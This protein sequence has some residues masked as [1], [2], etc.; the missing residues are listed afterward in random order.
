VSRNA[1]LHVV[2]LAAGSASRFGS[3]KQLARIDG[4]PMLLRVLSRA[5][6]VA[7]SSVSV[8]LGAHAAAIAPLVQR[9]SAAMIVNRA[10]SEGIGSSIRAA[11]E[12]L[13]SGCDGALLLLAD[14]INVSAIDMRHLADV[15][16]RQTNCIVAAQ[17]SG[18]IGV[19]AIFPRVDFRA[20][21]ELRGDRG[22]QSIIRR[23][24]ERLVTVPVPNAALDIDKPEDL[25][26]LQTVPAKS[27]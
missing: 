6:E 27:G 5:A 17:Y 21:G 12:R 8:V 9:S 11:A 24:P 18:I 20:L 26:L 25:L 10:W 22:A 1:A 2:V 14:Q 23:N 19:P 16:R 4:Q 7:G 13:P 15:W 3:P